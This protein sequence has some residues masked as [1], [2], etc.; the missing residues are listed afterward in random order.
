MEIDIAKTLLEMGELT[1]EKIRQATG[2]SISEVEAL[3]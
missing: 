3:K 2:L 1:I